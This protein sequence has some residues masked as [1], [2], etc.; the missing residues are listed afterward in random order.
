MTII[1]FN[2]VLL[3]QFGEGYIIA[4][5]LT[6]NVGIFALFVMVGIAQACQP[7]LSFNHGAGRTERIDDILKL[8]V[9]AAMGSGTFFLLGIWLSAPLI[10][11]IYLG[12]ANDLTEIAASALT[13]TSSAYL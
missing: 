8:G 9:K 1:L 3:N 2:Y 13:F 7:I 6:T 4:Y 12:N 5:G 11:S 10:A